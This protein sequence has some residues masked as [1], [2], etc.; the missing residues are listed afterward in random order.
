RVAASDGG[1]GRNKARCG[2]GIPEFL[3]PH[4][5]IGGCANGTKFKGVVSAGN[6]FALDDMD[7]RIVRQNAGVHIRRPACITAVVVGKNLHRHVGKGCVAQVA[8]GII[9]G[10]NEYHDGFSPHRYR[11]KSRDPKP[12]KG[13]GSGDGIRNNLSGTAG[14]RTQ[15]GGPDMALRTIAHASLGGVAWDES[16]SSA[17]VGILAIFG[18]DISEAHVEVRVV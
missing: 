11:G 5:V 18:A 1:S 15:N 9:G 16:A 3:G 17:V 8:R 6:G 14:V 12:A 7:Q 13:V 2:W 10:V 4:S